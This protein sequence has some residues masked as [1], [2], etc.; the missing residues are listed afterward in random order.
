[1]VVK[2]GLRSTKD[3][4]KEK[5][6]ESQPKAL[7]VKI[8]QWT[9]NTNPNQNSREGRTD[10]KHCCWKHQKIEHKRRAEISS[11]PLQ[12][13]EGISEEKN[14][15][16]T[17]SLNSATE[18]PPKLINQRLRDRN[19]NR[20]EPKRYKVFHHQNQIHEPVLDTISC[21]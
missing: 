16:K 21:Q 7:P 14:I 11:I 18:Y 12:N 3:C 20:F 13:R 8:P 17:L 5:R 1:M 19:W 15:D 10:K 4:R 2:Q 6:T 9:K